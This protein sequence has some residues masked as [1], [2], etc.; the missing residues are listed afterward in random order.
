MLAGR[1]D[2]CSSSIVDG[3]VTLVAVFRHT[4]PAALAMFLGRDREIEIVVF[5]GLTVSFD[6]SR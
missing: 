6:G 3:D 4:K 1:Q 5:H 2:S